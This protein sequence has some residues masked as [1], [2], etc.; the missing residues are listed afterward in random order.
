[1]SS[2]M[3]KLV[4]LNLAV[5]LMVF[6]Y[7]V[8]YAQEEQ[9]TGDWE[10]G[11]APLYLW[12]VNIEGD[13]TMQGITAPL[14]L[15]FE[16]IF[17]SLETVFTVHFEGWY[18]QKWGI[19]VDISYISISDK[20]QTPVAELDVSFT[21]TMT[22]LG[23]FYRFNEGTHEF[24]GLA[25]I[26]YNDLENEVDFVG[27][28]PELE[29]TAD[30]VDLFVGGRYRWNISDNWTLLV[31]G[32]IGAGGSNLTWNLA[33]FVD[34]H[35]WKHVSILAGYRVLDTDYDAGS[36]IEKFEYDVRMSGPLFAVNI[37]W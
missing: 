8:A 26:R 1:M 27:L 9:D 7:S 4:A 37:L 31:R 10:F 5:S 19:L 23:A 33:G 6:V 3:K 24:E 11:L 2:K 22:E 35:P 21:N 34:F 20:Q 13:V 18:K 12:A 15:D 14:E 25:G 30:W 32:D 28:P 17:D 36:G 16:D 29:E